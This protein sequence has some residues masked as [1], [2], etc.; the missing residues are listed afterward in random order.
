MLV[1]GN[2]IKKIAKGIK[3]ADTY[4]I[5][6]KTGG[7]KEVGGGSAHDVQASGN[8]VVMVREPEKNVKKE[9]KV[10]V[11]D[12]KGRTL[13]PGLLDA[14]Y[15][16]M[17]NFWPVSK[18]L[19]ANFGFHCIAAALNARATLMRGFTTVRDAAANCGPVARATNEG[20]IDGPRMYPCLGAISQTAGHF[21]YRGPNEVPEDPNATLSY[22]Q[23]VGHTIVADGVPEVVKRTREVLRMGATQIKAMA[24]GGVVSAYDPLDVTEY[25]FEEAKAICDVAKTW[26]TYVMIHVNTDAAIR[27]WIE[28][29]AMCVEHGFFISEG[30]AKLMA[31]KGVWWSM[32]PFEL[33]GDDAPQFETDYARAKYA[34]CVGGLDKVVALAKKYGVK[35]AFGTDMMFDPVFCEKQGKFLAKLK[36]W[37]TP[38][39]TLKMAT[40]TN[41]ELFKMCGPR[42]PYPGELGVVKEGALADL[43]LVSG[44]PLENLDLVADPHKNFVVIMKDGKIYKNTIN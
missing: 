34:D 31:E 3:I 12:G 24:G 42:D 17:L 38:F 7:L 39:E 37:Y 13:M 11:I 16:S 10:T 32:Q 43:L 25:T 15:H 26:N 23:Q 5:D 40:S 1:V 19:S 14:H 8:R 4:E 41:A 2:K 9:V 20:L 6:V 28:A 29:G 36:R 21:D 35:T 30:T 22:L 27:M 44:N 18:V 33:T